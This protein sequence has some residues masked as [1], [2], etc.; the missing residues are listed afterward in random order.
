[1][2]S[3]LLL[4]GALREALA[5][6]E[7]QRVEIADVKNEHDEI[8]EELRKVRLDAADAIEKLEARASRAEASES[9][10]AKLV[11]EFLAAEAGVVNAKRARQAALEALDNERVP[12]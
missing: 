7:R 2:S 1:M 8:A 6:C 10:L 5:T 11:D 9:R 3:D 4:V 12:F